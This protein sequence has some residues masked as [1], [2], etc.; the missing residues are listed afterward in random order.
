MKP[1]WNYLYEIEVNCGNNPPSLVG[2]RYM[3]R[4]SHLVFL[5]SRVMH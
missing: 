2:G 4:H 5:H 3:A 1:A